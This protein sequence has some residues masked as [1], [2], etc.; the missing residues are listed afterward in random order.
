MKVFLT[1]ASG[2]VGSHVLDS[3]RAGHHEVSILLQR[4]SK[5]SFISRHV[6]GVTVHYGSLDDSSALRK[7]MSGM[8]AVIHCAGKTKA[9]QPHEFYQVNHTGTKNIAKAVNASSES[10]RRF[11][12]ISS[13]AVS[14]PGVLSRPA[15]ETDDPHPVSI[16]GR[17]K[18]LGESEIRRNCRVPWT[19]LR[20]AVVYGPRD[21]DFLAVFQKV[22]Q[23]VMPLLSGAKRPLNMVYGPDVAAAVLW[24]L[25]DDRG[26][27]G[28]YHVAAEP[29]CT[30]EE[31]MQEIAAAMQSRSVRLPIPRSGLYLACVIKEILSRATGRPNI[32]SR[33]KLAELLAPGWVCNTDRI[34]DELGFTA[35]TSLREGVMQTLEWY[36]REGWV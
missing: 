26:V 20:P 9:L 27:G 32:L 22:R 25:R 28:I 23:R 18:L 8:E 19:I 15:R 36:R 2:F 11:I 21:T 10:L 5:T 29:P 17:S 31:F 4:T 14:G 1:G 16:Y 7:A 30:D 12:Y 13:Q 34:R 33:Q 35:S 6:P 3:L 24:C